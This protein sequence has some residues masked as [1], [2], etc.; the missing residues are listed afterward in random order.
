MAQL[1]IFDEEARK[2][3]LAGVS[4]LAKGDNGVWQ[5]TAMHRGKKV[6]VGLDDKG[7]V[8]TR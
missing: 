4:K 1:M 5:G 6:N 3:L 7:N 2:S 8:T